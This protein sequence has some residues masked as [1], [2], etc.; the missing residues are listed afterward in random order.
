MTVAKPYGKEGQRGL[1]SAKV[2]GIRVL[3]RALPRRVAFVR[4]RQRVS[5]MG[6]GGKQA[7]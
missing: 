1:R 5:W 6:C 3:Q 4:V 7:G 2:A